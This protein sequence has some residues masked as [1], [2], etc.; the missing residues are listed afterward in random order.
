MRK[1]FWKALFCTGPAEGREKS[2][3]RS[4]QLGGIRQSCVIENRGRK[5][6]IETMAFYEKIDDFKE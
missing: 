2:V 5:K 4:L 6:V 1:K 3:F